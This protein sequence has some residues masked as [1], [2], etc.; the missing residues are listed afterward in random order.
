M[1][2][3]YFR[4]RTSGT[5][6]IG[7]VIVFLV[8][9]AL[10]MYIGNRAFTLITK[11]T[12]VP[13]NINVY[14][15][16]KGSPINADLFRAFSQGGE[17]PTNMF[18]AIS[19]DLAVLKPSLIR[20][21]HIYDHYDIVTK[22]G[23]TLVYNFSRLDE[24]VDSIRSAGAIPVFSLSYMPPVIA[25]GGNVT[26]PPNN[27]DDWSSVVQATVEYYSGKDG[28]NISGIYYE[29]WNEPDLGIFGQWKLSGA[30]NY[31]TL[32]KHAAMG[33]ARATN[34]NQYY[35]GGPSTTGLYKDWIVALLE[36]GA[37][38]DF[39]SW[40]SY[41]E[42]PAR[43]TQD[44]NNIAEWLSAYEGRENLELLITE[45]GFTGSKDKRYSTNYAASYTASVVRQMLNTDIDHL[46]T[47]QLKDGPGQTNGDGWGI[48]EHEQDGK[49]RKPRFYLFQY[50]NLM[51]GSRLAMEGEGTH[52]TGFATNKDNT[53]RIL[54]SNFDSSGTHSENV[55][56]A[57]WGLPEGSYSYRERILMG[58][59]IKATVE[60]SG[61]NYQR[62]IYMP[63]QSVALIEL[64]KQ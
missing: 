44:W 27:W 38:V 16:N 53:Y 58:R 41:I 63:D 8:V 3:F 34:T 30:K 2:L 1:K 64:E 11:A 9:T 25:Q 17:E 57:L 29:V 50:L 61:S 42:E 56:L 14:T 33:A 15:Q 7:A 10:F 51:P 43:F 62:N 12:V 18:T 32:Y 46:F 23:E 40:H 48:I 5:P 55:P 60:I 22:S 24:V 59:D 47:F 52:V 4:N 13:A 19:E 6:Q 26:N 28:R 54:L 31:I 37:R 35:L 21:D 39:L 36:S 20:V 49:R 45:F